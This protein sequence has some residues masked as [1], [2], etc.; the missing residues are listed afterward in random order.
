MFMS[1]AVRLLLVLLPTWAVCCGG[2]WRIWVSHAQYAYGWSVP[3]LALFFAWRRF[4]TLPP[5]QPPRG[6]VASFALLMAAVV[7]LAVPVLRIVSEANLDWRAP[8]AALML[9]AEVFSAALL[10][11]VGGLPWLKHFL[12]PMLFPLCALP[13]PAAIERDLI[14]SLSHF[15]AAAALE[16]LSWAGV[17]AVRQGNLIHTASG[18]VGVEEACSGIRS[19]QTSFMLA[20]CFGELLGILPRGRLTLFF[21]APFIAVALNL[22]RT[23]TLVMVVS[24]AGPSQLEKAHD[25]VAT[26]FLLIQVGSTY[27]VALCFRRAP[28]KEPDQQIDV[29]GAPRLLSLRLCISCLAV[30][31]AIELFS[32]LWFLIREQRLS[33]GPRWKIVRPTDGGW[34]EIKLARITREILGSD[35]ELALTRRDEHGN[36]W[37]FYGLRWAPGNLMAIPA[38]THSPELCLT[39]R[40]GMRLVENMGRRLI[41]LDGLKLSFDY[42][43][44]EGAGPI[45]LQVIFGGFE[46]RGE[47]G[48]DAINVRLPDA[49]ERLRWSWEGRRN[50]GFTSLEFVAAGP[51][52]E[53]EFLSTAAEHLRLLLTREMQ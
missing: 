36:P 7:M 24:F 46:D 13:W 8:Y 5:A 16:T 51:I 31:C 53:N 28:F 45:M 22:L 47:A 30:I 18:S 11:R 17:F 43:R 27:G 37:L 52:D 21:L 10:F 33:A 23:L 14:N 6:F 48:M 34:E 39:S 1:P 20:L 12:F 35:S 32:N 50:R 15:N 4:E 38:K 19:L 29:V 40:A 3:I 49:A 26:I 41:T 9:M 2:L 42:Y 44:F 25:P